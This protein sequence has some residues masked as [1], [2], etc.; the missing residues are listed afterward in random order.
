MMIDEIDLLLSTALTLLVSQI[1]CSLCDARSH[2]YLLFT[3]EFFLATQMILAVEFG[4]Y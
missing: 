1:T 4:I 2:E 3:E